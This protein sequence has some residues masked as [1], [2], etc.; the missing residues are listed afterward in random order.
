[1]K[2]VGGLLKWYREQMFV[3]RILMPLIDEDL[4]GVLLV[5]D[6]HEESD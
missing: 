4:T 6:N 1:M 2:I 3:P 5:W